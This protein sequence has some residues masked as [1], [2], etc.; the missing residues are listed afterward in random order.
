M[1]KLHKKI[2]ELIVIYLRVSSAE[3]A[4]NKIGE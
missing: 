3:Q 2:R 4:N 1:K